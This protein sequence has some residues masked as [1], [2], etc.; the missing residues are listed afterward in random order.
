MWSAIG[1]V[2]VA[3][4][5][6]TVSELL[7][8]PLSA[9][10][11]APAEMQSKLGAVGVNWRRGES[12][13]PFGPFDNSNVFG[14]FAAA[15]AGM[16]MAALVGRHHQA[17]RRLAMLTLALAVAADVAALKVT[18]WLAAAGALLIVFLALGGSIRRVAQWGGAFL[19]AAVGFGYA[20]RNL[21]ADRLADLAARELATTGSFEALSRVAIWAHYVGIARQ[22]PLIGHGL[23]TAST[24]G[25]THASLATGTG[26]SISF[27]L[28][29]ESG[30]LGMAVDAGLVGL[31]LLVVVIGGALVSGVRLARRHREDELAQAA[32]LMAAGIAAIMIGNVSTTAFSEEITSLM[33][34]V[35]IGVV[36][37]A[38]RVCGSTGTR[39]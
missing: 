25:P 1:F 14:F 37:V 39:P 9:I 23:Y 35:M 21:L 29:P 2:Q 34:G 11:Y 10:V 5:Y 16:A 31:L 24:F 8:S 26:A 3:L 19:I 7:L 4:G 18:G 36:L 27:R 13:Q 15:G 17:P 33:L 22:R 20:V 28:P 6:G 32:G 30:Y 12:V 38:R